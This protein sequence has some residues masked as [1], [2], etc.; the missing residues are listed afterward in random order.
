MRS[1]F[2]GIMQIR[3]LR[4]QQAQIYGASTGKIPKIIRRTHI[5]PAHMPA[6]TVFVAGFLRLHP[7]KYPGRRMMDVM[8]IPVSQRERISLMLMA[9]VNAIDPVTTTKIRVKNIIALSDISLMMNVLMISSVIMIPDAS[10][11]ESAE[12]MMAAIRPTM[13]M[14]VRMEPPRANRNV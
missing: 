6:R 10:R 14:M 2:A 9:K 4:I 1:R 12:D 7:R 13:I 8:P 11:K 5:E 3:R